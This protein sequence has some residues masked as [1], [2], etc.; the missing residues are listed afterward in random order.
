VLTLA[1]RVRRTPGAQPR[2]WAQA[3]AWSTV[4][5]RAADLR[6][7]KRRRDPIQVNLGWLKPVALAFAFLLAVGAGGGA[8]AVASQDAFPNDRLYPVKLFT[9]DVH[10][11]LTFDDSNR[12][13]LLLDQSDER[14]QEI[15]TLV[16]RDE[17]IP[18]NVLSALRNRNEDAQSIIEDRPEQTVLLDR[19]RRQAESQERILVALWEQIDGAARNEYTSAVAQIHNSRLGGNNATAAVLRPEDLEGGIRTITGTVDAIGDGVWSV[20]GYE[21]RV[22]ARTI[23][24]LGIEAGSTA[25]FTVG[26]SN[27]GRRYAYR[28]P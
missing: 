26:H 14:M 9:E 13:D 24:A 3:T 4:R 25:T 18:E 19:S 16:S 28:P 15:A 23:G 1:E 21:I 27:S 2:P 10:V 20:G 22:D 11:W 5:Q 6:A 17:P 12:A 7:G 8:T